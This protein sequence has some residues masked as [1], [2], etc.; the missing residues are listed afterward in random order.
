MDYV[1]PLSEVRRGEDIRQLPW[2]NPIPG[3]PA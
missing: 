2:Q 3:R 1:K